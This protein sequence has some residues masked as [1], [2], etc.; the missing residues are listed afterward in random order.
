L[1]DVSGLDAICV[2]DRYLNVHAKVTDGRGSTCRVITIVDV[3]D[4]LQAKEVMTPEEKFS[5]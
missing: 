2:D 4:W 5:A 1:F 3:L